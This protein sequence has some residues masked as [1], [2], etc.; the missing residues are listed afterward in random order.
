M[1]NIIEDIS[2]LTDVSTN[3]LKKFVNVANFAI[4]HAV[5]ESICSHDDIVSIDIGIGELRVKHEEN[6]IYYKFIPSK[7]LEKLIVDTVVNGTSPMITKV[8][9]KLQEKIDRAY[10][11]LI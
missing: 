8:D 7:D 5:Y 2:V 1:I 3:N 9:S 11:E 6:K 4:G 10:K